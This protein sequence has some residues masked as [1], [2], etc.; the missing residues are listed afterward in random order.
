MARDYGF[1]PNPFYGW[2]TLATC[3]PHIRRLASAGDWVIGTGSKTC[4][5]ADQIVYAMC[6][7]ETLSFND[8]WSD[9]RFQCKRP[10]LRGSKKQAFGD[11]IYHPESGSAPWIQEDSHH[12]FSDGTTNFRNVPTDTKS[13]RVLLSRNFIYWGGDGPKLPNKFTDGSEIDIRAR[14]GYKNRFPNEIIL[15]FVDWIR[16]FGDVGFIGEPLDWQQSR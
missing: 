11:N 8:Y 14:R 7:T 13:D 1:A 9:P 15:A 16:D 3:Q 2:C 12:T 5:R 10:N 6:V 4:E